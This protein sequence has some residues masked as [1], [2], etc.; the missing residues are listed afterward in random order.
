VAQ[1][2]SVKVSGP[3]SSAIVSVPIIK[4]LTVVPTPLYPTG[5]VSS[6]PNGGGK[7]VGTA[8]VSG[9]YTVVPSSKTSVA[10]VSTASP[11]ASTIPFTASG[12]GKMGGSMAF[13]FVA[14]VGAIVLLV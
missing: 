14:L 2:A 11:S 5:G 12:A 8:P 6:A 13:A 7:A 10:G 4:T 3:S 9:S 1:S